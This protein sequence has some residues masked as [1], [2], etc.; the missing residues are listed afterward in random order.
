M[1]FIVIHQ[2]YELWFK[3]LLYEFGKLQAELESGGS[4]HAPRDP[5]PRAGHHEDRGG[6]A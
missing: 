4:T 1:L 6:P 5:A 2:V 3:Q